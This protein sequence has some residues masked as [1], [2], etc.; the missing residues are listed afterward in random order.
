ME[1]KNLRPVVGIGS[2]LVAALS[3][4]QVTKSSVH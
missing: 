1:R 2:G 4:V 3:V